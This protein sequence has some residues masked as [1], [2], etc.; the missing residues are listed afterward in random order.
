MQKV[1]KQ[2]YTG[3]TMFLTIPVRNLGDSIDHKG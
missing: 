1:K 3:D 2:I